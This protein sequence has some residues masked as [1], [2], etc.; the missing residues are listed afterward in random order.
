M[1]TTLIQK[2]LPVVCLLATALSSNPVL[3]EW[4]YDPVQFEYK[5]KYGEFPPEDIE[6]TIL[7]SRPIE[8]PEKIPTLED[9]QSAAN[10]SSPPAEAYSAQNNAGQYQAPNY[11][12]Y[13]QGRNMRPPYGQRP[14]N[15]RG[16]GANAPWG[17]SGSSFSGPWNNNR[18]SGFN[19]P[20][21]N[22]RSGSNMPWGNSGP[23]FSGPWDNNRGSNFSGP[24]N[25]NRGSGFNMPGSNNRSGSNMP[26]GNSGSNF[27]G[28]WN[29]NRPGSGMS[30]GN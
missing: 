8:E 19:M 25:N 13:D 6:Q 10:N 4:D 23:S 26:W 24:W 30:W 12:R 27:S 14:M 21:S 17:N 5:Q 16:P 9:S 3:S 20:G 7:D 1:K 18:G 22:N 15:N 28:P 2:C 29:N 11:G